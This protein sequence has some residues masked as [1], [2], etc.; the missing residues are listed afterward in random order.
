MAPSRS[1]CRLTWLVCCSWATVSAQDP[2]DPRA[3]E[4]FPLSGGVADGVTVT[5]TAGVMTDNAV[6]DFLTPD[7][8][9]AFRFSVNKSANKVTRSSILPDVDSVAEEFGSFVFPEGPNEI[10]FLKTKYLWSVWI[11]GLR[12]DWFDYRHLLPADQLI[13]HLAVYTGFS[14]VEVV[15][16]RP[17]CTVPCAR[18]ECLDYKFESMCPE[19]ET[20]YSIVP[21]DGH[22]GHAGSC[23]TAQTT[24]EPGVQC[25]NGVP[26]SY[27]LITRS[28]GQ[29]ARVL[30][31]ASRA[32]AACTAFAL[33]ASICKRIAGSNVEIRSIDE[34]N[35]TVVVWSPVLFADNLNEAEAT[36]ELPF[37]AMYIKPARTS[38]IN[39]TRED[40][41]KIHVDHLHGYI[42][43]VENGFSLGD[44]KYLFVNMMT[45]SASLSQTEKTWFSY[46][47]FRWEF[48]RTQFA[49]DT[50]YYAIRLSDEEVGTTACEDDL[51]FKDKID[52]TCSNY[53]QGSS[54]PWCTERGLTT[55]AFF[56]AHP[57]IDKET[58]DPK[59]REEAL[60]KLINS[61]NFAAPWTCCDCG[62]G[63]HDVPPEVT[64][65]EMTEMLFK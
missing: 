14:D 44:I 27:D 53:T 38:F 54:G 28:V 17:T 8:H 23:S 52:Q 26:Q 56:E 57:D 40:F 4:L 64:D 55:P 1:L 32:E 18:R 21:Q 15:Q 13:T 47:P 34:G 5:V 33:D 60:Y 36:V 39:A 62:G 7:R 16:V 46:Q 61:T 50:A 43:D 12:T 29:W 10:K 3:R 37:Y 63:F 58:T 24:G 2:D 41:L 11:N 20:C 6:M 51:G 49:K 35:R 65:G 48:E 9:V 59:E 31:D 42:T 25:C 22:P 19:G 30:E 45:A